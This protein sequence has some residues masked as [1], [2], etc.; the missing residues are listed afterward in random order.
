MLPTADAVDLDGVLRDELAPALD[1]RDSARLH[2][3]LQ[4]LVQAADHGVL[5]VV[6]ASHVDALEARVDPEVRGLTR[7]V[8]EL[9]GVQERLGRDAPVVQAGP[10]D[11]GALDEGDAQTQLRGAQGGCIPA[12]TPAQDDDVELGAAVCHENSLGRKCLRRAGPCVPRAARPP[13]DHLVTTSPDAANEPHG[14]RRRSRNLARHGPLSPP[15]APR[16]RALATRR[17]TRDAR[18]PRRVRAH[19]RRCRAY[20]EPETNVTQTTVVLIATTGE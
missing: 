9:G 7:L 11:L 16:R 5:V 4:A 12:A 19:P 14:E 10:T 17:G 18:A 20:V 15:S 6:D 3:A 13:D 2:E 1:E 8:R